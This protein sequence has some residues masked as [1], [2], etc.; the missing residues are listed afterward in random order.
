MALLCFSF[1]EA[2]AAVAAPVLDV[3]LLGGDVD[4]ICPG[5]V[6]PP[7]LRLPVLLPAS[8]ATLFL[9]LPILLSLLFRLLSSTT[10]SPSLT[11]DGSLPPSLMVGTFGPVADDPDGNLPLN[12]GRPKF[13]LVRGEV[14]PGLSC[15][16]G[17]VLPRYIVFTTIAEFQSDRILR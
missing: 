9:L 14:R 4:P 13:I 2:P 1:A 10:P 15:P 3:V 5:P 7:P 11:I 12:E 6:P 17:D 16:E 8:L